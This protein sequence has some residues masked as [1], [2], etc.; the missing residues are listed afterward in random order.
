MSFI[1]KEQ[2]IEPMGQ[3]NTNFL[4]KAD[5]IPFFRFYTS[6]LTLIKK[7]GKIGLDSVS[8]FSEQKE[9]VRRV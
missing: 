3:K 5:D 1:E 2:D 7:S 6:I 4:M 9:I 8:L